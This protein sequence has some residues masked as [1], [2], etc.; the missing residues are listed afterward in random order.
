MIPIDPSSIFVDVPQLP[1]ILK[2]LV[3]LSLIGYLIF[4]GIIIRQVE[5]MLN[6]LKGLLEAPIQILAWV[7]FLLVLGVFALVVIWL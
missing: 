6:S 1:F 7:H 2:L 5:M 3:L 4:A